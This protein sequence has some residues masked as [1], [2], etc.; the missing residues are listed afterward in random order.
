MMHLRPSTCAPLRPRSANASATIRLE[1]RSPKLLTRS[2]VLGVNSPT[3][4]IPRSRSSSAS[5]SACS[6]ACN[7]GSRSERSPSRSRAV[8]LC[9]SRSRAEIANAPALSPRPEASAAA[10][11]W[12]VTRAIA[13]T[14]T[15]AARPLSRRPLTMS[16]VRFI[17]V[18]S[19]TDV[20][21][22]FMM[23]SFSRS[24]LMPAPSSS[25]RTCPD[26]PIPPRSEWPRRQP[27][28]SCCAKA[29]RTSNPAANKDA[30]VRQ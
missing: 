10:I 25:S 21:P 13:E 9:R 1:S 3:A 23:T 27:R 2:L 7:T 14:T 17:A 4:A 29:E 19:S 20:P 11:N 22:N 5:I 15:T 16:A 12:S 6:A 26:A 8:S 24:A 18:A 28:E 30:D